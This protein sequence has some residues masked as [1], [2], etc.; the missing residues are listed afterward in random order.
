MLETFRMLFGVHV[1]VCMTEVSVHL[2]SIRAPQE[3]D[4]CLGLH[5]IE[6]A[7]HTR[8]SA[9]F[10]LHLLSCLI[11][12]GKMFMCF[13]GLASGVPQSATQC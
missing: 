7:K 12:C 4:S 5:M 1:Y 11:H 3:I 6:L 13:A 8:R 10:V 2:L 9:S